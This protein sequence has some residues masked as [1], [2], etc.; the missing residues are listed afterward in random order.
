[1]RTSTSYVVII[2]TVA[3]LG[4]AAAVGDDVVV[5]AGDALT[6]GGDG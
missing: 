6:S 2:L 1:M 4:D 3:D 5:V